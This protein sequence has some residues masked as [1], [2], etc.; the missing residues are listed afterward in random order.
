V[1]DNMTNQEPAKQVE[2]NCYEELCP[3]QIRSLDL[4]DEPPG[5]RCCGDPSKPLPNGAGFGVLTGTYHPA[6]ECCVQNGAFIIARH[7]PID[8]D[9]CPE[10]VSP[11]MPIEVRFDGCSVPGFIQPGMM[12]LDPLTPYSGNPDEPTPPANG[13]A[14]FSRVG[15][16]PNDPMGPCDV[17]DRCYQSCGSYQA[18]CDSEFGDALENVCEG[19]TG[20]LTV[21]APSG[22]FDLV[23]DRQ[24]VCGKWASLYEFTV[25][26]AG[27]SAHKN[28]QESHC[29]CECA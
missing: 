25:S 8:L 5:L 20:T 3:P 27:S 12:F 16:E 23:L 17:H 26:T 24:E 9:L 29:D 10:A 14:L 6:D 28:G 7:A 18:E 22:G 15:V 21:P 4:G 1:V 19:V 13:D 2:G 11:E